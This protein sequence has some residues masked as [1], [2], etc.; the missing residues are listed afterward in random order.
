MVKATFLYNWVK[1]RAQAKNHRKK[2]RRRSE[3]GRMGRV[4]EKAKDP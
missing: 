4:Q 1:Q 3:A 2:K